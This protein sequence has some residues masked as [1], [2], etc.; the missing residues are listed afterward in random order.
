MTKSKSP[1]RITPVLAGIAHLVERHLAKVE[2]AS[3]SLV[4]RS[5]LRRTS[6]FGCPSFLRGSRRTHCLHRNARSAFSI[7]GPVGLPRMAEGRSWDA[8]KR[9]RASLPAPAPKKPWGDEKATGPFSCAERAFSS[10]SHRDRRAGSRREPRK[11]TSGFGCP[12]FLRGSRRTRCLHRNARSA[13]S[14]RGPVGFPRMAEG[15]SWDAGKRVRA[16][17]PAPA[18]KKPWGDEKGRRAFFMRRTGFFFAFPP[19]P[20]CWVPAGV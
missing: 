4:A 19:G 8:G 10:H 17:L 11:R 9:V 12:S 2:V 16:S 3:S 15:R 7:R 18:P 1:A 13:F 6:G 20:P 5:R 14:I